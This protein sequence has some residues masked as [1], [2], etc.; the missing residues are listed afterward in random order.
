ML[1]SDFSFQ[2]MSMDVVFRCIHKIAKMTISFFMSVCSH[3]TTWLPLDE[4][5]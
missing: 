4:S 2:Y 5:S 1:I 3:G